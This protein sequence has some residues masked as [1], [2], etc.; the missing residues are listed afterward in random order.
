MTKKELRG[1]IKRQK[2]LEDKSLWSDKSN[3]IFEFIEVLD[4]FN[5]ASSSSSFSSY[6]YQALFADYSFPVAYPDFPL[7]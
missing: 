2:E 5:N 1:I 7:S 6:K 3:D 4:C